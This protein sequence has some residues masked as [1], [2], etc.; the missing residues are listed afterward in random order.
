MISGI[1]AR[2][3]HVE[4]INLATSS[5][6]AHKLHPTMA[7]RPWKSGSID[8]NTPKRRPLRSYENATKREQLVS[9]QLRPSVTNHNS[10][11]LEG[12]QMPEERRHYHVVASVSAYPLSTSIT[13]LAVAG[14]QASYQHCVYAENPSERRTSCSTCRAS[15]TGASSLRISYA[16]LWNSSCAAIKSARFRSGSGVSRTYVKLAWGLE[17]DH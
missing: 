7:D 10:I 16:F 2:L 11:L 5:Y 14:L 9:F 13:A 15:T 6:V 1:D 12:G 17:R 8:S 4:L 3:K